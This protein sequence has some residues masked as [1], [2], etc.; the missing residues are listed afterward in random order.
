[1]DQLLRLGPHFGLP[2][3]VSQRTTEGKLTNLDAACLVPTTL[4]VALTPAF[5]LRPH[6]TS[7]GQIDTSAA[8]Q[9]SPS[10]YVLAFNSDAACLAAAT[11]LGVTHRLTLRGLTSGFLVSLNTEKVDASLRKT[12]KAGACCEPGPKAYSRC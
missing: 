3:S 6:W 4:G 12:S 2:E 9:P 7:G 10:K 8:T 5:R 11:M 1:M